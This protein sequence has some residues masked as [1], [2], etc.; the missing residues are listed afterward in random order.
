MAASSRPRKPRKRNPYAGVLRPKFPT[1]GPRVAWFIENYCTYTDGEL[2]GRPRTVP[3]WQ[4]WILNHAFRVDAV[5]GL[6]ELREFIELVPRGCDKSGLASCLGYY[7]L[8]FDDEGAPEIYSNAWG[9]EQAGAVFNPAKI[10]HDASPRLQA[11]TQKFTNAITCPQTAGTWRVVSRVADT[12]Q[13]MKPHWLLN[14][15]FHVHKS[16]ETRDAIIRGMHKRRQ[17]MAFDITTEGRSKNS[18][19]GML[20]QGFYD[21]PDVEHEEVTPY[22]HTY[23]VGRSMMV[24]WGIPWGTKLSDVDLENPDLVR[25][26]TPAEWIDVDELIKTQLLA[27][28]KRPIDFA[29]YH[30]NMLVDDD[31][32]GIPASSWDA[33][34]V[35]TAVIPDGH[36]VYVGVD[37]GY[38]DDWSAVVVIGIVDERY[39]VNAYLFQ[40]PEDGELYLDGT[41]GACIDQIARRWRITRLGVDPYMGGSMMQAWQMAG[42]PVVE[43]RFQPTRVCPASVRL[44]ETIE[45][46]RLAHDGALDLREHVLN[47]RMRDMGSGA[48]RFDKPKGRDDLKVDAGM[49]LLIAHDM[50]DQGANPYEHRGLLII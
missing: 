34:R 13:G 14:D 27:P 37:L 46:R 36:E 25:A 30:L 38:R 9:T 44:L 3:D 17:P 40:P 16:G 8:V 32:Q 47:L 5:T 31:E 12:K 11:V 33:C 10:M 29:T 1:N 21:A 20:Q 19:L 50:V 39:V 18:P 41:V 48:W 49:A 24:R 2:W 42:L 22:L 7:S 4:R 6:R 35:D 23:R 15:E 26:C 45:K 28:G 43:Y